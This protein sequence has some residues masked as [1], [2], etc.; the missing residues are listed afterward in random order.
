M[1]LEQ[2]KSTPVFGIAGNFADHLAQAGEAS[3]FVNVTTTDQNA[4]K[5]L[6]P[7][8]IPGLDSY[9][10]VYPLCCDRIEADF[11]QTIKLQAEPEISVLFELEYNAQ[12]QITQATALAFSAF[13]DC[14]IRWKANKIS[15]KKNWGAACT[16]VSDQWIAIDQFSDQGVLNH[17]HLS[18]FL[19]RD[20]QVLEY[21][22]DSPASSYNYFYQKLADWIIATLNSQQDFGPLE[23]MPQLIAQAGYPRQIIITLGATRYTAF[24]ETGYLKPGDQVG[25]F[26][27]NPQDISLDQIAQQFAQ[28]DDFARFPGSALVQTIQAV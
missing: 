22:V 17:Y 2:L 18:C 5:G 16:G 20:G 3:D 19:K 25:V 4:P 7:I 23:N 26:V 12:Q 11:S 6:F 15:Q 14:S 10:G 28:G 9:L 27:Y 24:G 21:G 13:N 8:Y 1:T